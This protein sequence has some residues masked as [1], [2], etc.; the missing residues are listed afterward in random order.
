MLIIA[1]RPNLLC[2]MQSRRAKPIPVNAPGV[3]VLT[4]SKQ[5][6]GVLQKWSY[7]PSAVSFILG[8]R[9]ERSACADALRSVLLNIR[10][11]NPHLL[12]L[13]CKMSLND[14][15]YNSYYNNTQICTWIICFESNDDVSIGRYTNCVFDR[16]IYEVK[17]LKEVGMKYK[18]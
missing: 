10:F 11:I 2:P 7:F 16:R 1:F 8:K 17:K 4:L 6:W 12:K 9:T 14:T 3:L 5:T 18:F 13:I 15:I